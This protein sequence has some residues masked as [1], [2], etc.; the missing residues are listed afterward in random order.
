MYFKNEEVEE[1]VLEYQRTRD[2]KI[3]EELEPIFK[4]LINGVISRYKL[5]RRN[6]INDDLAQEAW[7]GIMEAIHK[8]DKTKGDAF[9][10]FTAISKN[11]IFWYLKNQYKDTSITSDEPITVNVDDNNANFDMYM[12]SHPENV[13]HTYTVLE[14]ITKIKMSDLKIRSTDENKRILECIKNKVICNEGKSIDNIVYADLIRE[15]Q[16]ETKIPKKNIRHVLEKIY[17]TYTGGK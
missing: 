13:E 4:N 12:G 10:F 11:K 14:F 8:W 3:I 16:K 15:I 9:S 5:L 2:I 7:V 17:K 1:R 6:Y